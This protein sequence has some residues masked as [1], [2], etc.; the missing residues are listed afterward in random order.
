MY[1]RVRVRFVACWFVGSRGLVMW[2]L[3]KLVATGCDFNLSDRHTTISERQ[4]YKALE[5]K[6]V[7]LVWQPT[8]VASAL[9]LRDLD[10]AAQSPHGSVRVE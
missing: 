4:A 3:L 9:A 5:Q 1:L 7:V 8:D 2:W 6:G 10:S